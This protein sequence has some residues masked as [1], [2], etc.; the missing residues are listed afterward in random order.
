MGQRE[1]LHDPEELQK[2]PGLEVVHA[3]QYSELQVVADSFRHH[4]DPAPKY[5]EE[6]KT[7]SSI[8]TKENSRKQRRVWLWVTLSCTCL[9]VIAGA[10]VGGILGSKAAR[11]STSGEA[12]KNE[13]GQDVTPTSSQGEAPSATG[14]GETRSLENIRQGSTLSATGWRKSNGAEILLFYQGPDDTA[15]FSRYDSNRASFAM[16]DSYWDIPN[17]FTTEADE[18]AR[19]SGTMICPQT[20]L[21]YISSGRL[22][23]VNFNDKLTPSFG[24]DSIND[25]D[26]TTGANS[27]SKVAVLGGY[28][29]FYQKEDGQLGA[30][31]PGLGE[32]GLA[33]DYA[34][35]WPTGK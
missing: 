10:V 20:E 25:M 4:A 11:A 3:Q 28:G 8:S 2:Q 1:C 16:N 31:V 24:T 12:Q 21:F 13:D 7:D 26:I 34:Q 27:F 18:T 29:V 30:F 6:V 9:L 19:L 5:Y 14:T 17:R 23:G 35:S 22:L 32:D 33:E 15:R